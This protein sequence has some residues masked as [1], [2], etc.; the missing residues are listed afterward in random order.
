MTGVPDDA[1]ASPPSAALT[2]AVVVVTHRGHTGVLQRCLD[3]LAADRGA[4]WVVVI[5][6]GD[7]RRPDPAI[8]EHPIV[9][10]VVCVPNRGFGAAANVGIG[11]SRRRKAAAIAVLNDDVVVAP[12]WLEPLRSAMAGDPRL[13]AVQP[14]LLLAGTRPARVN[15]VGVEL[16][17]FGAGHDIGFGEPDGPAFEAGRP[18]DIFTGGAVLLRGEFLDELGGFDER[19]FLYY[20]D[21]DLALRGARRGWRYRCEPASAVCHEVGSSSGRLGD[22]LRFLQ[23]RNR[24]LIAWR[25]AAPVSVWR[26]TWLAARR[27]RHEPRATHRRALVDAVRSVPRVLAE[28]NGGAAAP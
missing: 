17:E 10:E 3:S 2:V 26:A 20:E 1:G 9:D 23:E 18:I 12:G 16:D 6:N 15:S 21:V 14:K 13:G 8:A 7:G 4:E 25:F 24:L 5:D 27:L 22:E 28:R 11:W 19:Y